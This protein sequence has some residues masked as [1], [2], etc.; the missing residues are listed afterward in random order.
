MK[1]RPLR[2]LMVILHLFVIFLQSLIVYFQRT[3]LILVIM[4][5]LITLLICL[6]R[7]C[8][9]WF[10]KNSLCF[11]RK[12]ML[13]N[14]IIRHSS[15]AFSVPIVIVPMKNGDIKICIDYRKLNQATK[16]PIFHIPIAQEIFDKLGGNSYF[17]TLVLSEVY[18]QICMDEKDVH[19]TAF[20]TSQGH[21]EFIR[22]HFGLNGQPATFQRALTSTLS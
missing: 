14:N 10:K 18:Y 7:G 13:E 17:T 8:K 3:H 20:S 19:K 2:R 9:L 15:S 1:H 21:F 12:S 5:M 16:R 4:L 22:M 6:T 11:R